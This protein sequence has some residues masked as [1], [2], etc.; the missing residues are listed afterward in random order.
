MTKRIT[1]LLAIMVLCLLGLLT[2]QGYLAYQEYQR[3]QADFT[4]QVNELFG[5]SVQAEKEARIDRMVRLFMADIDNPELVRIEARPDTEQPRTVFY[6]YDAPSGELEMSITFDQLDLVADTMTDEVRRQFYDRLEKKA[7]KDFREETF[8]YWTELLAQRIQRNF[9][10][11]PVDTAA[12]RTAFRFKLDSL[13]VESDFSVA[14]DSVI[15]FPAVRAA[16]HTEAF[17]LFAEYWTGKKKAAATI[18]NP[19][20]AIFKRSLFTI[21]GSAAVILLTLLS[22]FLL[23]A[24]IL[25]Q[26][27]LSEMKDDFIDNITHELQTPIAALTLAVDSMK[28]FEVT[29]KKERF[30]SYLQ[31]SALE[32]NR[33]SELVDGILSHSTAQHPAEIEKERFDLMELLREAAQRHQT[34]AGKATDIRLPDRDTFEVSSSRFHLGSILDNL[35]Q[36]AVRYSDEAGVRIDIRLQPKDGGFVMEVADDGWG[37][38]P[39]DRRRI[40]EKFYRSADKDRNYTVKGLGIGLYHVRQCVEALGGSIR[41]RD[42]QPRGTVVEV[43]VG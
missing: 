23:F 19:G 25:R 10:E 30:A 29:D 35:L 38:P 13:G 42:N 6:F 20:Y 21:G 14:V 12:L 8:F 34:N 33:L 16:V 4:N 18:Q 26:K 27:Q 41:V 2:M 24:T 3:Q 40:F 32:L 1:I 15:S 7:R 31:V 37:V 11:L 5:Q 17:P 36:N 9:R 39:D 43:V 28:S 22:F